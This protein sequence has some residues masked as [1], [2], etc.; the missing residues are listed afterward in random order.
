MNI[1]KFVAPEIIFGQ[2]SL[3]QLGESAVRIGVSKVFLVSDNRPMHLDS[4]D[5]TEPM[6]VHRLSGGSRRQI[7]SIVSVRVSRESSTPSPLKSW[8]A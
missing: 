3:S 6:F 1:S 4:R 7:D 5:F 8:L 2:G